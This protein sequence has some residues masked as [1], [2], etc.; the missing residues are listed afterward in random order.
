MATAQLWSFAPLAIAIVTGEM[1]RSSA[2]ETPQ[3]GGPWGFSS[4]GLATQP[5]QLIEPSKSLNP[6]GRRCS[7]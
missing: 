3:M 5:D 1:L 4:L 2:S 7:Q 6:A